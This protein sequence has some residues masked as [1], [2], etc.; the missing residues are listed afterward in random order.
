MFETAD[1]G[2]TVSKSEFRDR[3]L[4]LWEELLDVQRAVSDY[5]RF[6]ILIDF[7]GVHGA[8]KGTTVNLLNK[9]MDPRWIITR[10]YGAPTEGERNR[11]AYWKFWR[12]MPQRGRFG[13]YLS[14]R[15]SAPFLDYVYKKIS[16]VEFKQALEHI[17]TFERTLA[18]D[19]ALIL[20]FWMHLSHDAQKQRLMALEKDPLEKWRVTK[21]DWKHWEMYDQFIEA[22]ETLITRTNTGRAPWHIVEGVDY[23]YRSLTVGE[24]IR[25]AMTS[26]LETHRLNDEIHEERKKREKA[27]AADKADD[28]AD[29]SGHDRPRTIFDSLN[30][31][32]K[33]SKTNYRQ[34]VKRLSG[35]L[36]TL[37]REALDKGI[38]TVLVFE[39]PD[40]AGKGGVIRRLTSTLDAQNCDVIAIA[41]PTED[42]S[43]YNY[44]WRFWK[45]LPRAGYM[46]VFDR[47]WYGRVLVERVEELATVDEWERAY[48]EIIEFEEQLI[49][50]GVVLLKF[51]IDITKEEQKR[52]FEARQEAPHK[53]WKLTEEDWRNRNQW[54]NY[55]I[56]AHE[57][58]QKTSTAVTPWRIVEGNSKL[59]ARVE[60]MEA[61]SQALAEAVSEEKPADR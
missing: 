5:G 40:A 49:E 25:D 45:S 27:T 8:G 61:V 22:A 42:E 15:Y 55:R 52:R 59:Y 7:A 13:L 32:K 2:Q 17:N 44:L 14:G 60:V 57:M 6:P 33:I 39:G 26:H 54:D 56:A 50:H 9:W 58:V 41:A 24:L 3:E 16:D 46:T 38:S 37:H 19:G 31:S 18:D 51:W 12:D 34:A 48:S 35:E 47:S 10:A 29:V 36:N 23:N 21:E 1:L 28:A 20:K 43:K 4:A 53:R 30:M 11:P